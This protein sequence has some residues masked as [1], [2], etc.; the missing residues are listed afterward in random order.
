M[1]SIPLCF[2][3]SN[4]RLMIRACVSQLL[5]VKMLVN[6]SFCRFFFQTKSCGGGV[7]DNICGKKLT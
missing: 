2:I 7:A 3:V 6:Y 1:H 5:V 4:H